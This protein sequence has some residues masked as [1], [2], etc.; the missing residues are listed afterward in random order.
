MM[1]KTEPVIAVNDIMQI[2][3]PHRWGGC[4]MVVSEVKSG[5]CQGYVSIPR[6]DGQVPGRAYIRLKWGEF[7]PV[8]ASAIFVPEPSHD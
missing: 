4:L 2:V 7:E 3:P 5:G 1:M 6:N 8:G